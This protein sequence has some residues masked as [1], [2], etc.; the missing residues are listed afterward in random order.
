MLITNRTLM[1]ES[2]IEIVR[3]ACMELGITH[4]AIGVGV[5]MTVRNEAMSRWFESPENVNLELS[6]TS[7]TGDGNT[8]CYGEDG[9]VTG[10]GA[11]IV[12]GMIA[13]LQ[14]WITICVKEHRQPITSDDIYTSAAMPDDKVMPGDSNR[15]GAVAINVGLLGCTGRPWRGRR[16]FTIYVAVAGGTGEENEEAARSALDYIRNEATTYKDGFLIL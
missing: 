6:I 8:L 2:I 15:K 16:T 14:R 4:G 10:D 12:M 9:K 3:D 11:G 1:T 5:A 7:I 13:G